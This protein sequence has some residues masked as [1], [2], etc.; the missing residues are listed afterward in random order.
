[1]SN[2]HDYDVDK[3]SNKGLHSLSNESSLSIATTSARTNELIISALKSMELSKDDLHEVQKLKQR[4]LK[5][6][7]ECFDNE[8][9]KL[10]QKEL[11]NLKYIE[12]K[13]NQSRSEYM[14]MIDKSLEGLLESMFKERNEIYKSIKGKRDKIEESF[15]EGLYTQSDY[16]LEVGLVEDYKNK[17]L[18]MLAERY[19]VSLSLMH[20][21]AVDR[22]K[23]IG[24]TAGNS[25]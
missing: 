2:N 11:D 19:D 21:D 18:T 25:Y 23:T 13:T 12:Q 16:T 10:K 15:K 17:S 14:S 1:M 22:L 9:K 20:E 4:I 5:A 24:T 7:I 6:Q 3:S 8:I